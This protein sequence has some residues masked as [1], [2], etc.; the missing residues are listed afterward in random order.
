MTGQRSGA[1]RA[2]LKKQKTKVHLHV[3]LNKPRPHCSAGNVYPLIARSSHKNKLAKACSSGRRKLWRLQA[4]QKTKTKGYIFPA[5]SWR[6]EGLQSAIHFCRSPP[7]KG[8][9]LFGSQ[10]SPKYKASYRHTPTG[11]T[12]QC[13]HTQGRW[14][15]SGVSQWHSILTNEGYNQN[16]YDS[17]S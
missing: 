14:R 8:P 10:V 6:G 16:V 11:R 7:W 12:K 3:Y 4:A 13:P 2:H 5:G 15:W 1:V 17:H 9:S